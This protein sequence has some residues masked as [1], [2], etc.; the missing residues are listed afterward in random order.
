[1]SDPQTRIE[2]TAEEVRRADAAYRPFP[3]YAEWSRGLRVETGRLG[4][5]AAQLDELRSGSTPE[6]LQRALAVVKRAAAVDT[7]AIEGLYQTDRGFTFTVALEAAT[8][9]AE[10][11]ERGQRVV[12]LFHAQLEAYEYVLDLA[13]RRVPIGEA[14]IRTLHAQ[15]CAPQETYVVDTPV[16]LQEQRLP[17][18]EYKR[19]PNHV[20][21]SN[22]H[23]HSYAPVESTAPEM[24]RLCEEFR[25]VAFEAADPVLQAAYAHYALVVVHPFADG[26]GRVARALASVFTYRKYS[27]P[28]LI[29]AD[30]RGSYLEALAKADQGHYETYVDFVTE[31]VMD[32]IRLVSESLRSA[33]RPTPTELVTRVTELY[34]TR[35]GFTHVD[36]DVAG[37]RLLDLLFEE[38][39]RSASRVRVRDALLVDVLW[40]Q[41]G[42]LVQDGAYR[43][44]AENRRM[45][46]L[47]CRTVAPIAADV[48]R[49]FGVEVPK[50]CGHE[51][52][53]VI[54]EVG[55]T[56]RFE[57]RMR[58]LVPTPSA[59]FRARLCIFAERV[60]GD[61]LQELR[62]MAARLMNR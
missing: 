60:I 28:L 35:G 49:R 4:R 59:A 58:E 26:N 19:Y 50:D 25:S 16:G 30:A 42:H 52:D 21:L 24:A 55:R 32:A 48:D 3:S 14:W 45:V 7:G 56:A 39:E 20:R 12:D 62:E 57:A 33:V 10:L 44:P 9:Q 31:R 41:G 37:H 23:V 34:V 22:G 13:T 53:V 6:V 43:L 15:I 2:A 5:Y 46:R 29:L 47:I 38:L 61:S 36:V 11:R 27:T 51:D 1:M 17:K 18:G 54:V 8:W 40:V